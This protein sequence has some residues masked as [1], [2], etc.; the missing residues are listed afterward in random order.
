MG[1]LWTRLSTSP[2]LRL[3]KLTFDD[4]SVFRSTLTVCSCAATS[5]IVFGRLAHK[6]EVS[7]VKRGGGSR[8]TH[9]FSTHG[10]KRAAFACSCASAPFAGPFGRWGRNIF[11]AAGTKGRRRDG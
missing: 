10:R 11:E 2:C 6:C 7:S 1:Q 3:A 5:S 8:H 4:K 9:Y